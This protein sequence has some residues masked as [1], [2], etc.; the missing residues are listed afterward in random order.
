[1][2]VH[3]SSLMRTNLLWRVTSVALGD[4][5]AGAKIVA[6]G[7]DDQMIQLC[8]L[9]DAMMLWSVTL[10]AAVTALALTPSH[11]LIVGTTQ[12]LVVLEFH[13]A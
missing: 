10:D 9:P 13:Q 8:R 1:M 6:S 12:G 11:A 7:G 5:V 4:E 2:L 3:G